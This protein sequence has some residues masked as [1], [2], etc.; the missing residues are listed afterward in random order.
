M[1]LQGNLQQFKDS[2][3]NVRIQLGKDAKGNFTLYYMMKLV[4]VNLLI[5]MVFNQ[6]TL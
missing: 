3:G 1:L 4:K 6:V 5:R 2:K